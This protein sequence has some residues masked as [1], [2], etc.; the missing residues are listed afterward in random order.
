[1]EVYSKYKY[2]FYVASTLHNAFKYLIVN[3][4]W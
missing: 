2:F 4:F 3:W 1:M